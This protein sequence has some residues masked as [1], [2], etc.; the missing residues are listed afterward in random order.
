MSLRK[1]E[2]NL[3]RLSV[4]PMVEQAMTWYKMYLVTLVA[5]IICLIIIIAYYVNRL[6]SFWY[7][8]PDVVIV[9]NASK[10]KRA[11]AAKS[12]MSN[13][14]VDHTGNWGSSLNRLGV[15]RDD[16]LGTAESARSAAS[17]LAGGSNPVCYATLKKLA[18]KHAAVAAANPNPPA[19]APLAADS[20]TTPS[21]TSTIT[22]SVSSAAKSSF[23]G[24][25]P[26]R[27]RY[28]MSDADL[29][30]FANQETM[31]DPAFRGLRPN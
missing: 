1:T 22:T 6:P 27:G 2:E 5:L 31:V 19:G 12:G 16:A 8:D 14:S 26:N 24:R 3:R 30:G 7:R 25:G 11:A 29:H 15:D 28:P 21:G 4:D 13:Y 10:T 23:G 9:V 17:V 18:A 20:V